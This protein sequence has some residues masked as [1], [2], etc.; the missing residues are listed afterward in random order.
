MKK[1]ADIKST[2]TPLGMRLRH[3]RLVQE[4]TLKQLAQK[5][6]CSESLL[7]KLENDAASPSLAMLHRLAKALETS[8]ADLMADDWTADQPVLKPAQ[9]NR[10]RFLQRSKK[11]GIELENL[12]WHHKGGLLQG[13]IHIIEPGVASDGLIEHHGE[14]MGYV[15]EGELELRL[16]DDVW[17]LEQGD[18]FYF[19][20]QIPHGYRNIGTVVAR[21]LWVNTPVT[22]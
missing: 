7:S 19:P 20:S 14:E 16:G 10:K 15:L 17:T 2:G 8:I 13:N 3:A 6:E 21:V 12:T 1:N 11:G 18:S 5:V 9:R 4:M 22:F